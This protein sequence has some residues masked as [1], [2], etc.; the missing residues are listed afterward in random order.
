VVRFPEMDDPMCHDLVEPGMVKSSARRSERLR[1]ALSSRG[2]RPIVAR[3]MTR[4]FDPE[5]NLAIDG[6][7]NPLEGMPPTLIQTCE[8]DLLL[9]EGN[10][11]AAALAAAGAGT[12]VT[13]PAGHRLA[14]LGAT[15]PRGGFRRAR[16]CGATG[17]VPCHGPLDG[18]A[19]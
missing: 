19:A 18:G 2:E 12:A 4:V 15:H 6:G 5:A 13:P 9:D 8:L 10:R 11:Y 17:G 16:R 3:W 1:S 14:G 7:V